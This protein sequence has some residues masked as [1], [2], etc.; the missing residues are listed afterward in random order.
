MT[1]NNDDNATETMM[2]NNYYSSSHWCDKNQLLRCRYPVSH[3]RTVTAMQCKAKYAFQIWK[4]LGNWEG[5]HW[6]RVFISEAETNFEIPLPERLPPGANI[7][8]TSLSGVSYDDVKRVPFHLICMHMFHMSYC[9][10]TSTRYDIVW[11]VM[12]LCP[13]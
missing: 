2:N 11:F 5:R 10:R 9:N 3:S 1:N 4:V 7:F 13:L 6:K 12:R 8:S